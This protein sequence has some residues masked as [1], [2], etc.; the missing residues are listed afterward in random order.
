MGSPHSVRRTAM[1][2]CGDT[3]VLDLYNAALSTA[4]PITDRPK[5]AADPHGRV[6]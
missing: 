5:V 3:E 4:T 1:H 6:A 2:K